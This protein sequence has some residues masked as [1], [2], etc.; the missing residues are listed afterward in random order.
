MESEF[1]DLY[2]VVEDFQKLLLSNAKEKV[3]VFRCH[4]SDFDKWKDTMMTPHRLTDRPM[5]G[6]VT[7][8]SMDKMLFTIYQQV[9][10]M[11]QGLK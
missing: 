8:I 10:Y 7:K 1:G 6:F 3:I 2:N 4:S 11:E 5:S 9:S